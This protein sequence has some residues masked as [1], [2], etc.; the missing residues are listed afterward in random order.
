MILGLPTSILNNN[1]LLPHIPYPTMPTIHNLR[2][3]NTGPFPH[4]HNRHF[5]SPTIK[6]NHQLLLQVTQ[7]HRPKPDSDCD[8]HTRSYVTTVLFGIGDR[9]D[10]KLFFAQ[11]GYFDSLEVLG[12]VDKLDLGLVETVELVV[13]EDYLLWDGAEFWSG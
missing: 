5:Y 8:R 1:S 7:I 2:P 11:G 12:L 3:H 6:N 9:G 4:R 13:V 10:V